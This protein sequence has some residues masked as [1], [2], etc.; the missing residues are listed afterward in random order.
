M[1]RRFDKNSRSAV[2]VSAMRF[3]V[4]ILGRFFLRAI[5]PKKSSTRKPLIIPITTF[6]PMIFKIVSPATFSEIKIGS[7]SSEVDM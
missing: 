4:K 5:Q 3:P 6:V 7:I 1:P 2:T